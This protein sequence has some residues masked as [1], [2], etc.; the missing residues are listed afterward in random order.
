M[1]PGLPNVKIDPI[2]IESEPS[3]LLVVWGDTNVV[4]P[5]VPAYPKARI[6]LVNIA[7]KEDD[8][9]THFGGA[10]EMTTPA[11]AVAYAAPPPIPVERITPVFIEETEPLPPFDYG[12]A[13]YELSIQAAGRPYPEIVATVGISAE[14][15]G[16]GHP[17]MLQY[18]AEAELP[19]A[20]RRARLHTPAN[21]VA[22]LTGDQQKH[23]IA[24]LSKGQELQVIE[25]TTPEWWMV[26]YGSVIGWVKAHY[27][28]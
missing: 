28:E 24:R 25:Y 1:V 8:L 21:M 2:I 3:G 27:M 26:S 5:P 23:S 22:G 17:G 18:V 20:P 19:P 10:P 16:P 15:G 13:I 4:V 11:K 6:E 14:A 7:F 12:A 9:P